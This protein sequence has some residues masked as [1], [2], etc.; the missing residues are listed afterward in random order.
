MV[1]GVC[2]NERVNKNECSKKCVELRNRKRASTIVRKLFV[3]TM[4]NATES[5]H[6]NSNISMHSMRRQ[7]HHYRKEKKL[8]SR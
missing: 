2:M 6:R 4:Q 3:D 8:A 1:V 7:H 5:T